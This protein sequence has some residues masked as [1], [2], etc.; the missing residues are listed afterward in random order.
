MLLIVFVPAI[1]G[2][3]LFEETTTTV[4]VTDT[5]AGS[6]DTTGGTTETSAPVSEAEAAANSAIAAVTK[7]D[8]IATPPTLI[9]GFLQAGS[10]IA[11]PPMEFANK[12]GVYIGFDVDLCTAIA[13]KM[14]LQLQVVPSAWADII[15]ALQGG[16]FDIIMSA[17]RITEEHLAQVDFTDPYLP[18]TLA[19]SAPINAPIDNA[20]GLAGKTVGV[21]VASAAQLAVEEIAGVKALNVYPTIWDAFE[22]MLEGRVEAVVGDEPVAAYL[23]ARH[24]DYQTK[25]ANTG[26]IATDTAYGYAVKKDN[27]ALLNAMN[28]ALA[29]LKA[30]GVYQKICDKWSLAGL[31]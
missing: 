8:A 4:A 6:T 25:F 24:S 18:G 12:E 3:A 31:E 2:C 28:A 1:A 11:F 20:A 17:M 19:I 5:S 26:V 30:E 14:G 10:D 7:S 22:A 15:P 27:T 23:I 16:A 29:E 9:G 13:K 21:Q